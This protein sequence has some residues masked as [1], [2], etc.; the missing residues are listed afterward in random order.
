MRLPDKRPNIARRRPAET[1]AAG[2][3]TLAAA[4]ASAGVPAKF[5]PLVCLVLGWIPAAITW[6]VERRK[7]YV[8][9]E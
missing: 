8:A 5:L 6:I 9:G 1:A 2:A 4:L 3:G 7:E